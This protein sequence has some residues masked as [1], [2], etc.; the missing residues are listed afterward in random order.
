M[1]LTPAMILAIP[2]IVSTIPLIGKLLFIVK[3]IYISRNKPISK[4]FEDAK[5][6]VYY[7][8]LED[9]LLKKHKSIEKIA[10]LM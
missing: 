8:L 10:I 7:K 2:Q 9:A 5:I 4:L 6:D 3:L 1:F